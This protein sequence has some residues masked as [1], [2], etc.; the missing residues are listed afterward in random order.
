MARRAI[1]GAGV[2]S[3]IGCCRDPVRGEKGSLD[4]HKKTTGNPAKALTVERMEDMKP[5]PQGEEQRRG[6]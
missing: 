6:Q 1:Q 2:V 4:L 3:P 5:R